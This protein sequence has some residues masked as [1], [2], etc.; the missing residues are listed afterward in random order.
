M[1][2]LEKVDRFADARAWYGEIPIGSLYTAGVAGERFL[3]ALKDEGRLLATHCEQCDF[4]YLPP[5]LF[6]ERCFVELTDWVEVGP[7]AE[8][9]TFTVMTV[10]PDGSPLEHPAVVAFVQPDGADGG[11]L[12][13]LGDVDPAQVEI[14]MRVMPVYKPS[15]ERQGSILDITHFKP[16]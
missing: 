3:R 8:V 14:G 7:Q 12:H 1:P 6:C 16:A 5:A 2:I 9:L 13:Y 10:K 4:T 15:A 11:L